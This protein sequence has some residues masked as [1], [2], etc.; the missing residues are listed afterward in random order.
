MVGT[1]LSASA[2][3][4]PEGQTDRPSLAWSS[5]TA[6][7]PAVCTAGGSRLLSG[8]DADG[9]APSVD[10]LQ[11]L[12][13][14]PAVPPNTPYMCHVTLSA[15][16]APTPRGA[17]RWAWPEG[18]KP[19]L[20]LCPAAWLCAPGGGPRPRFLRSRCAL[21]SGSRGGC[22]GAF[23]PRGRGLAHLSAPLVPAATSR[24]PVG[25]SCQTRPA[26]SVSDWEWW[27]FAYL[28]F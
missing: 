14:R 22:S 2:G 18:A 25:C 1:A 5:L 3:H 7:Q 19:A 24:A 16:G 15:R 11:P 28:S 20:S 13:L 17:A 27:V 6:W 10:G 9:H 23:S 26:P 4:A 8:G 21:V 12:A